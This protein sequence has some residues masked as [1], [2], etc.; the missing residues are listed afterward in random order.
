M[1][2]ILT[3]EERVWF[4]LGAV[5]LALTAV[6]IVELKTRKFCSYQVKG[7]PDSSSD[8][9]DTNDTGDIDDIKDTGESLDGSED[10]GIAGISGDDMEKCKDDTVVKIDVV[11]VAAL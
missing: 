8:S 7:G 1:A 2:E 3:V 9:G 11:E 6:F 10:S 4:M 5:L